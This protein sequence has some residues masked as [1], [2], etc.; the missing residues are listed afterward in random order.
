MSD[1]SKY[2]S[3]LQRGETV[4]IIYD[5]VEGASGPIR[6]HGSAG[7]IVG[8]SGNYFDVAIIEEG[9]WQISRKDLRPKS[10]PKRF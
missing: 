10:L 6:F 8:P 5:S 3:P 7:V 4:L 9:I 1:A 2:E